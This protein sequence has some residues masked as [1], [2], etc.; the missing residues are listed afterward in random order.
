MNKNN[1]NGLYKKAPPRARKIVLNAKPYLTLRAF[2]QTQLRNPKLHLRR[3]GSCRVGNKV[4]EKAHVGKKTMHISRRYYDMYTG[5][6]P[7]YQD[8][9]SKNSLWINK[10]KPDYNN[11][12]SLGIL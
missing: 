10:Q 5:N 9:D 12:A 1:F 4:Y 3:L 8:R 2:L 11:K 7:P 6:F